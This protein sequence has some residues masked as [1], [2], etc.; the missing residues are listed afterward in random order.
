MS[1][2]T[3]ETDPAECELEQGIIGLYNMIIILQGIPRS[4]RIVMRP[5]IGMMS[6]SLYFQR[7]MAGHARSFGMFNKT[8]IANSRVVEGVSK[9]EQRAA[10]RTIQKYGRS[11][12]SGVVSVGYDPTD[13]IRDYD[14]IA[15]ILENPEL[16]IQRHV[17]L[18]N[19]VIGFEQANKY[20]LMASNGQVLGRMEETD[21]GIIKTITRQLYRLHRPFTVE[22]YDANYNHVLTLRRPF[23]L[24]NSKLKVY[25]PAD[26]HGQE[27]LIGESHQSWHLYRRRYKLFLK[28][29]GTEDEFT[30]FASIDS[31]F[32]AFRFDLLNE[33]GK[34]MGTVDRN[35]VGLGRELF[36]DSG[37]Y[38]LQMDGASTESSVA[39]EKAHGMTLDQRAIMLATAIS[40]DFDYFSRHSN[41][42]G[43][44]SVE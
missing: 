24:V 8:G 15:P 44:L 34:L 32:L 38:V 2:M 5:G 4:L 20:T 17:E 21:I 7:A 33:S 36:T 22:V 37:V 1:P 30:Q 29:S 23:A 10:Y 40:I 6:E 3:V 43:L 41:S 35:W 28:D 18:M 27:V 39:N 31:P 14:P 11:R 12:Q 25:L 9:G 13:V 42:S 16:V 19:V 26:S